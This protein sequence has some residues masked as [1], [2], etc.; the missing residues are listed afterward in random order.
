MN[1]IDSHQLNQLHSQQSK[2]DKAAK[3]QSTGQTTAAPGAPAADTSQSSESVHI[4]DTGRQLQ[5][6]EQNLDT[7]AFNKEKV[8]L[9][10]QAIDDGTYKPNAA[11]IASKMLQFDV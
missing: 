6:L 1:R 10:K 5:A 11:S 2:S 7:K 9:I 8:S 3:S 4:S